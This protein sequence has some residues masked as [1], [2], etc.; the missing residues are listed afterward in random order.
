MKIFQFSQ[1]LYKWFL[2]ANPFH[3][4]HRLNKPARL[5][6]LAGEENELCS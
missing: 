6:D 2:T 5:K 4:S 3:S 1:S